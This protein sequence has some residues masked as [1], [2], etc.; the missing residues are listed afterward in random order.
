MN[1]DKTLFGAKPKNRSKH[2]ESL[3]SQGKAISSKVNHYVHR[4]RS[5]SF[6]TEMWFLK[7]LGCSRGDKRQ[8]SVIN[9]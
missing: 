4:V 2:L 6:S 3:G 5:V 9:E 1:R 8:I 7:K